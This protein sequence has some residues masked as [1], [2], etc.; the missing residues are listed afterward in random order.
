[1]AYTYLGDFRESGVSAA[2]RQFLARRLAQILPLN[3]AITILLITF[4]LTSLWLFGS[5]VFPRVR[6]NHPLL[7]LFTNMLMLPGVGIGHIINWP[8]WSISVEFVAYFLFPIFAWCVFHRRAQV[9]ASTGVA[10]YAI[11]ALVCVTGKHLGPDGIHGHYFPPW[12]DLGRCFSEFVLGL[13]A[14][15]VY[16]SGKSASLFRRDETFL[17][18]VALVAALIVL[19][20]GDLF[21]VLV[22]P[23]LILSLSLNDGKVAK[24]ASARPLR[25]LGV[26]SYS[27][28]L[29]HDNFRPLAVD[30]VHFL[31]PASISPFAG[32]ALAAGFS[33][34]MIVPA[35]LAY[36]WIEQPGRVLL[37][38]LFA[39][40]SSKNG[41]PASGEESRQRVS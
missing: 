15:R 32:M 25:F 22:F 6:P 23:L 1:M 33:I 37:R 17:A 3:I 5:N 19:K 18:I 9:A 24:I 14:F 16:A 26:I 10:A 39:G 7:D 36:A 12:R 41:P 20:A 11:L 40:T 27:L 28:Y 29:V 21:P 38:S 31:Y 35:W 30:I 4:A 8:A 34:L 2:Y 13:I